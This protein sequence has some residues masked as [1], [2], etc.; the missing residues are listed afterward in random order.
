[1]KK[2]P[3]LNVLIEEQE[4]EIRELRKYAGSDEEIRRLKEKIAQ[5]TITIN[6]YESKI[7]VF[8]SML[9]NYEKIK[10]EL[11]NARATIITLKEKHHI[12]RSK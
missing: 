12:L 7:L 2:I 1:M 11:K 5:M 6:E 10:I 8:K 3:P 9:A 4:I